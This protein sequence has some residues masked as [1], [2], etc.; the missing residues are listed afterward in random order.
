MSFV[1]LLIASVFVT[2]PCFAQDDL[3]NMF[4]DSTKRGEPVIATFKSTRIINGQSNETLGKGE[5]DFRVGHRFGDIGGANGGSK[6]F[7]GMDNSSDIRIAFEYGITDKLTAGIG[8]TKGSGNLSQLYEGLIK[9][10]LL[11]QTTDN[12]VPFAVTL[13]GNAVVSAMESAEEE[14]SPS[15]FGKFSDRMSYTAQV[16][17]ARQF[18]H[19]F[20]LAVLPTYVHRNRVGYADMNNMFALGVGGRL[21]FTNRLALVVDYFVPFRDQESK[22]YA[23]TLGMEYYNTLGVGLEIE[24]GGHVFN[25]SFTNS[26]AI[27]E[28]QFIP[29]TTSTW[30]NGQFRWGFNISRR[31]DLDRKHK[32]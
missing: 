17:L 19:A 3:S 25:L 9:Y 2:A 12:R 30:T 1:R 11:Q 16:V 22:D 6:T 13:F 23:K 10:R 29:E 4:K 26:T 8:R 24:T 28:N 15:Y 31:F 20:S 7:F 5:L 27:L 32:K 21:K 14:S 18:G